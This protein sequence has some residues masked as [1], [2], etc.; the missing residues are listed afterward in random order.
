MCQDF[1]KYIKT[2]KNSYSQLGRYQDFWVHPSYSTVQNT[3]FL[4]QYLNRT[5]DIS[6]FEIRLHSKLTTIHNSKITDF[7]AQR[8]IKDLI[9]YK[10]DSA[11]DVI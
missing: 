6:V 5:V 4:M 10:F 9:Q 7:E 1:I 3:D 2:Q 11:V 8:K